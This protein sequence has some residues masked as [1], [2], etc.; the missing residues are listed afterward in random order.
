MAMAV[1]EPFASYL[2]WA[3]SIPDSMGTTTESSCRQS[4]Y[5]RNLDFEQIYASN[6]R[7]QTTQFVVSK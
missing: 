1:L 3:L 6:L 4:R 2:R 7:L 5:S